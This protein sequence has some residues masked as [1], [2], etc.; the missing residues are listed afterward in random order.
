MDEL[1]RVIA[2]VRRF[3]LKRA[4]ARCDAEITAIDAA[5][6]SHTDRAYLVTMGREDWLY[7]RKLIERE[8]SDAFE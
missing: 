8:M 1:K 4:L 6:K 2:L 5:E 7:E 3:E